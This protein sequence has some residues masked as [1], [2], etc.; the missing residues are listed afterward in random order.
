MPTPAIVQTLPYV[1]WTLLAAL[2]IGSFAFTFATRQLADA[3]PGYLRF[4]AV[5]AALLALLALGTDAGLTAT[6]E[7]AVRAAPTRAG[8]AARP[9]PD[10]LRRRWRSSMPSS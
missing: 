4:G 1:L 6:A 3:T 10:R 8:H 9:G 2:A 5:S 7:L